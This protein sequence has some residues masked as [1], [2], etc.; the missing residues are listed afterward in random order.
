MKYFDSFFTQYKIILFT[1]HVEQ[2]YLHKIHNYLWTL[3]RMIQSYYSSITFPCPLCERICYT[4]CLNFMVSYRPNGANFFTYFYV[5]S[6]SRL[7]SS[8]FYGI[9]P[10]KS[11][12]HYNQSIISVLMHLIVYIRSWIVSFSCKPAIIQICTIIAFHCRKRLLHLSLLCLTIAPVFSR[13]SLILHT[14]SM[15]N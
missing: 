14:N 15:K 4:L 5:L 10:Y 3:S 2:K 12:N 13:N 1:A 8:I 7:L 9:I 6:F 11:L